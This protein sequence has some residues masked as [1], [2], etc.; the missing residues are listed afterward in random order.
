MH[1]RQ[2]G[3]D[4]SYHGIKTKLVAPTVSLS[5]EARSFGMTCGEHLFQPPAH[6]TRNASC[7]AFMLKL[8]LLDQW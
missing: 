1:R 6:L 8:L 4:V 2:V 3:F 7:T 5:D